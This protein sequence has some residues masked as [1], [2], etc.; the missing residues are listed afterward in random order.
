MLKT[1]HNIFQNSNFYKEARIVSLLDRVVSS[2]LTKLKI[3]FDF[4]RFFIK[5]KEE[6]EITIED[7]DS[8]NRLA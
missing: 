2:I 6:L 5:N 8:A 1:I 4:S 7:F 3:Y